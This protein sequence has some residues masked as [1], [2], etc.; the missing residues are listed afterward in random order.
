MVT[1]SDA[2]AVRTGGKRLRRTRSKVRVH[3]DQG[4]AS[5]SLSDNVWLNS[6]SGVSEG[7]AEAAVAWAAA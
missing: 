6:I 3:L 2:V 1:L 5:N 7:V 4:R